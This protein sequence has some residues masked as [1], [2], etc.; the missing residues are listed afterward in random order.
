MK[1][2]LFREISTFQEMTTCS[3]KFPPFHDTHE[4]KTENL[5]SSE[6][7]QKDTEMIPEV[8]ASFNVFFLKKSKIF[9]DSMTP[10]K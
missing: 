4:V 5:K 7:H 3:W 8:C 10:T 2:P 9:S 1:S 6:Q